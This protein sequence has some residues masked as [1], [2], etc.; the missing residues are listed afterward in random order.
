MLRTTV[1]LTALALGLGAGAARAG[2]TIDLRTAEGVAKVKGQWRYRSVTLVE[3][4]G[5]G[6]DGSP[7]KT[8][9]YEPKAQT[10]EFDDSDWEAVDPATLKDRR[11]DG[12]ICFGWYRIRV[13]LPEGVEGKS[14]AFQTVVDD[15]GEIWV[16]GKLPFKVG[17]RGGNVVAGFNAQNRVELADPRPGKVYTI[18]IFA[19]NGPISATPG[20]YLFLREAVLTIE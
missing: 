19:I 17:Q 12:Q 9:N 18:A 10:P 5:K 15:Y 1:T 13:T 8:Y 3:V 14:V 20:N 11:G 6:P 4:E 7:V 16:D 2:E